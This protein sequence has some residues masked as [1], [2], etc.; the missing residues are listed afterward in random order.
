MS[1]ASEKAYQEIRR[2]LLAGDFEPGARLSEQDLSDECE[3]SRTP[4]REAL[5]RLALEYFVSIKPN[6]G[7]FVIDWSREDIADM[8]EMRATLEGFATE[9]ISRFVEQAVVVRTASQY[10]IE[11]L[12]RSNQYHAE[13]VEA[14]SHRDGILAET[15][16]KAHILAAAGRYHEVFMRNVSNDNPSG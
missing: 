1:G 13:L 9:I 7:A 2:R 5:R 3:V 15:I 14:I 12:K 11:D 4:V 6:R 16:M 10:T 8:F